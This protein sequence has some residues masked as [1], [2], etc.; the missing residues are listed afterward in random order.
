MAPAAPD[1]MPAVVLR[2]YDGRRPDPP[3]HSYHAIAAGGALD[4]RA[5]A[6]PEPAATV[7]ADST[8]WSRVVFGG[9]PLAD[10][11]V[12]IDGNRDAVARIVRLYG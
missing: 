2:L 4:I 8:G 7:T 10:G 12:R 3:V 5:G 1:G 6:T 9:L 11:D